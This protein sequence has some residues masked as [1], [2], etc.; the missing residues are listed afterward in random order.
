MWQLLSSRRHVIAYWL[1]LRSVVQHFVSVTAD[2]A[3][4]LSPA[5]MRSQDFNNIINS[6]PHKSSTGTMF[7]FLNGVCC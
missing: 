1:N 5:A 7:S 4:I 3:A 6:D 2:D